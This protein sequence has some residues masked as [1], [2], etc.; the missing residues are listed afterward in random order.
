MNPIKT[1]RGLTSSVQSKGSL[2]PVSPWKQD[3]SWSQDIQ[4]QT[5][6]LLGMDWGNGSQRAL[7]SCVT[8]TDGPS[9]YLFFRHRTAMW[10]QRL[11]Q[12][13]IRTAFHPKET[14]KKFHTPSGKTLRDSGLHRVISLLVFPSPALSILWDAHKINAQFV[15]G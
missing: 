1:P 13:E 14:W 10:S 7:W 15:I 2:F 9:P 4:L 12:A 8:N 5:P 3:L 11:I 6:W